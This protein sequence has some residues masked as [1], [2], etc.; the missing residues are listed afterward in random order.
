MKVLMQ[1][2]FGLLDAAGGDRIQVENT[3]KE[4]EKLD[5][6]VDISCELNED[7][8]KYD[9]VHVFQLDWTAETHLMAKNAKKHHKPLVLSPIHHKVEEVKRF[10]DEYVFDYRRLAKHLFKD[11]HKRDTFKN[12]YRSLIDPKKV[13]PTLYSVFK[14]LK[15]MHQ[16]T[17][18]MADVIL[19]QTTLEAKDLKD[20]YGVDFQW[21]KVPNG[22]SERFLNCKNPQQPLGIK[23][24]IFSVGRIEPRKDQLSIIK[25]VK[26]LRQETG[27]KFKLVFVG[28]KN[29]KNHI[30]Y[31]RIFDGYLRENDWIT[32]I[33]SVPYENIPD[34]FYYAKVCVSASW[35]ESTGLTLLEALYCG[36][37]AVASSPRAKEILGNYASYCEPGNVE[38]IKN[39]IKK[40][41]YAKRPVI[42]QE[43][44][45]EYT[46]KNA[47]AKTKKVY[48]DL[49]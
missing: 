35:F 47:A 18:D 15:K 45:R 22:V 39:A 11:Q 13:Y 44:R 32:Y 8:S 49:L 38:S 6:K 25:A 19:V 1:G 9:V 28:K 17:I 7:V 30:E 37:N 27:E 21:V 5:V 46:W 12:V 31:T 24:Y 42:D 14:G 26:M 20:T 40:E 23:D 16:E 33:E 10:D 29:P 2:R 41:Y 34:L 48:Q 3:A 4:L 43:M 36:T